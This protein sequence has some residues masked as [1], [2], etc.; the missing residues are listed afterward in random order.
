[1]TMGP[2]ISK[3]RLEASSYGTFPM[4]MSDFGSAPAP[5]MLRHAPGSVT[6]RGGKMIRGDAANG[7]ERL[8]EV[9]RV[10][11]GVHLFER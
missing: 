1:M 3:G 4:I 7:K 10:V 2:H 6:E 8:N 9:I 5:Q 11:I